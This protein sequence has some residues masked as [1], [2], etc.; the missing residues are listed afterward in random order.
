MLTADYIFSVV[1]DSL[2]PATPSL[3]FGCMASSSDLPPPIQP[4]S[5][6]NVV[7]AGFRLY[8]ANLK[9]YLRLAAVA[10]AWM[11][12]PIVI[13]VVAVLFFTA[14]QQYINA[15]WL[16]V[17]ALLVLLVFCSAK[18]LANSA[19]ICRM[20]F[21]ELTHQP[22]P[23]RTAAAYTNGR[24][25]RFFLMSLL[26]FLIF[27]ALTIASYLGLGI[28]LVILLVAAG[29]AE[30]FSNP[31]SAA[32]ANPALLGV[33]GLML[34]ILLLALVAFFIWLSVRFSISEV[35]LAIEPGI[36]ASQSIG[37]SWELTL[38]NVWRIFLI[39]FVTFLVTLPIQLLVQLVI[40]AA[41]EG[42]LTVF[43]EDS[44]SFLALSTLFSYL[45]GLVSGIVILPLWQA[46]KAVVYYDLRSRREG[47][48]LQL[49]D[50]T[51]SI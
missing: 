17:P 4:L 13:S 15:L 2:S 27:F 6:G 8:S 28:V 30:F 22:E 42:I 21:G 50:R 19:A 36:T 11:L 9:P 24:K 26:L 49:R 38:K 35:P 34:L 20:A 47:L 32:L 46:I 14:Q 43:P 5:I 40:T 48:D 44:P 25:W 37:R 29:G 33:G 31:A 12:L 45:V 41:Q 18:Y 3:G 23:W 7:N 1:Y 10:T 39:L 16:V 51:D